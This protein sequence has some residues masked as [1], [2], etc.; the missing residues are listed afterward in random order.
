MSQAKSLAVAATVII[1][2]KTREKMFK[3]KN[4]G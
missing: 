3:K 1:L 2:L 4:V